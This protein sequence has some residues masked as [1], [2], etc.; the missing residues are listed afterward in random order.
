MFFFWQDQLICNV[1]GTTS[2]DENDKTG[3][4]QT[5]LYFKRVAIF[6]ETFARMRASDTLFA[7]CRSYITM[8]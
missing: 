7:C 4:K 5:M 1:C 6:R 2:I 3:G 8:S